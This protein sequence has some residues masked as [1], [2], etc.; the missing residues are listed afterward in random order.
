[1]S[2]PQIE[3]QFTEL[4][5]ESDKTGL[6]LSFLNEGKVILTYFCPISPE[7]LATNYTAE[8]TMPKA[9]GWLKIDPEL[10]Q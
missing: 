2:S 3:V 7:E 8:I 4:K 5:A 10:R 6:R 9:E 1:M